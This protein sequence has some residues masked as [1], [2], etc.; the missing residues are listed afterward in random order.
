[1]LIYSW[2]CKRKNLVNRSVSSTRHHLLSVQCNNIILQGTEHKITWGVWSVSFCVRT[3]FWGRISRQRLET[4]TWYQWTTNRKWP[5]GNRLVTWSMT[6]R[7]L[8]RSMS[9]P[10]NVWG[11][12]NGW[13]YSLGYN[14][15]PIGNGIWGIKWSHDRWR[16][17][18]VNRDLGMF[19]REI[20]SLEVTALGRLRVR[21]NIILFV[22]WMMW[23]NSDIN[24]FYF[25]EP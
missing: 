15:A 11:L 9:W 7:D 17:W 6:S 24:L 23:M 4:E 25:T 1:M 13:R 12:E 22:K 18:S 3:G 20:G 21:A 2:V 19:G 5:M 14:R 16:R 8:E 10:Q